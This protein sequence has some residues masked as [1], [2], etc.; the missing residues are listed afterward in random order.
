MPAPATRPLPLSF[1]LSKAAEML[2]WTNSAATTVVT[3]RNASLRT[4][5]DCEQSRNT[6]LSAT[7]CSIN[8]AGVSYNDWLGINLERFTEHGGTFSGERFSWNSG[9]FVV[10]RVFEARS[11]TADL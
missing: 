11:T 6:S 4:A 7:E 10:C 1:T 3:V 5:F 2:C 9:F 8:E